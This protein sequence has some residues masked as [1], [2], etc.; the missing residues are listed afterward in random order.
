[1]IAEKT[2]RSAPLVRACALST[3]KAHAKEMSTGSRRTAIPVRSRF[4]RDVD[5]EVGQTANTPMKKL[6]SFGDRDGI[7]LRLYLALLWRCSSPPYSTDIPARQWAELLALDPPVTTYSRRITSAIRRLEEANL[8]SVQREK[9]RSSLITLLDESGDGTEYFPERNGTDPRNRW[10]QIPIEMWQ[11]DK[12]YGL[13]TPGLAMMLALLADA[14]PNGEPMWWSVTRFAQRIGLTASTRARGVKEL[15]EAGFLTVSKM[16]VSNAPGR[17]AKESVRNTYQLHLD[18]P[19]YR[20]R[21]KR[22]A[23]AASA[24]KKSAGS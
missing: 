5:A 12:F 4:I 22:K 15:K 23:Q 20:P 2:S 19:E 3:A 11:N 10:V 1:M 24:S 6:V 9:G 8:I 17:F 16:K 14:H 18:G 21:A 13:G 7:T